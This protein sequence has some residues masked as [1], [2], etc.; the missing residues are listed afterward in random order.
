MGSGS[1]GGQGE[2]VRYLLEDLTPEQVQGLGMEELKAFLH[3]QL[4]NAYDLKEGQIDQ[5]QLGL[6]R[7]AERFFILRIDT[8]WREHLQAMDALRESVGLRGTA[9]GS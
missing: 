2:G 7:E 4:R 1:P 9:R 8:L 3:E 6:I 5:Q